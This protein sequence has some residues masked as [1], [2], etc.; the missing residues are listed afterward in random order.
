MLSDVEEQIKDY[1]SRKKSQQFEG[2]QNKN[3]SSGKSQQKAEGS[4]EEGKLSD[5]NADKSAV[6]DRKTDID[7]VENGSNQ[8]GTGAGKS[9]ADNLYSSEEKFDFKDREEFEMLVE[10]EGEQDNGD[11]LA[12]ETESFST[13]HASDE[14]ANPDAAIDETS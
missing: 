10:G 14:W 7:G 12:R 9:N 5:D 8:P 11:S 13:K 6:G 3:V 1:D 4:E 2:Q